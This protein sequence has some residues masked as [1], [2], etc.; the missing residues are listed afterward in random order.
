VLQMW[1]ICSLFCGSALLVIVEK[2]SGS[3]RSY[4]LSTCSFSLLVKV[5]FN[6]TRI[7]LISGQNL[8]SWASFTERRLVS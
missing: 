3:L 1:A 2:T 4:V 5:R 6:E 7:M 8:C